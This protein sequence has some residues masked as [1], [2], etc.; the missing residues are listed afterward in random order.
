MAQSPDGTGTAPVRI[1]NSSTS[2]T[3]GIG[4]TQKLVGAAIAFGNVLRGT[5]GPNGLDKMLYKTNGE[6]AVTNDGAKIV[7]EL[8]V[9]HPAAKAFVSLAESQENACGDGVTSCILLASELMS[10]AGRLLERGLHPLILVKGY[11]MALSQTLDELDSR[12]KPLENNLQEVARTAL[13]GRSTEGALDHLSKLIAQ[14]VEMIPDSDYERVRMAKAGEGTPATSSLIPGIILEKRLALERMPRKLSDAKIAVLSCPLELEQSTV[15]AEIEISTPE[16]YER[17]IDAEHDQIE[18]VIEKA[19]SSGA[20]I[21]F[22]AEGIDSR[23]LHSL[24]DSGIFALGGL[25]RPMAEDIAQACGAKLCDHLDDLNSSLGEIESLEHQRL[26]GAEGVKER[27]IL[28]VGTHAGIVTLLVGGTDGVAAE[29]TIRG[30]YDALRSTCLAKEEGL[31]ILGGGSLHMAASLKV[32]EAAEN[33]PGRE[34]LSMEAFARALEGIPA[35]LSANA[36]ED[37]IDALLELR[38]LHRA[39]KTDSGITQS[40]KPGTIAS[41]WLPTYTIEHAISAACESACGLLR[42]DQVISARGD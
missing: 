24:A 37:K 12:S 22:S 11:E 21:I 6:A 17:F 23:V 26:E 5:F 33:C 42:V 4:V 9:K 3:S 39:G 2:V 20:N 18:R 25:E 15:A 27:I 40:G 36:G 7:A 13:V 10:E 41:V 1:T 8:L 31:V 30:L 28:K 19:K 38:S 29:E 34:R 16:Q 35:A 14:A 32:R